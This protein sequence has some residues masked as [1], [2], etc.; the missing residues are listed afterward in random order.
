MDITET[1]APNSDQL[2]AIE[3]VSGPRI[4]TIERVSKGNAEQPVN[5]HFT[6]FPRPWRPSKGMRRVLA[7]AWGTDAS[8]WSGRRVELFFD[9]DVTF[10]KDK[11]GGTRIS[12]M[13]H[14]DGPTRLPLLV[15]RGKSAIFTV[16]P[17]TDPEP[18]GTSTLSLIADTFTLKGIPEDAWVSGA[19]HYTSAN[20]NSL[21]QLTEDQARTLLAVLEQRPDANKEDSE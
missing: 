14:I 3:L 2:D 15:S 7:A 16:D 9:P 4:F 11:P 17:L 20:V 19:N 10:G 8:Q 12:R 18:V 1:L 21:D 6:N 13:S 5:I